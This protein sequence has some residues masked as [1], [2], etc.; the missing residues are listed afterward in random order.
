MVRRNER[1]STLRQRGAAAGSRYSDRATR[2]RSM[3]P[4]GRSVSLGPDRTPRPTDLSSGDANDCREYMIWPLP[5]AND[6]TAPSRQPGCHGHRGGGDD[7]HPGRRGAS[8]EGVRGAGGGLEG[9]AAVD[10]G[11][12]DVGGERADSTALAPPLREA[13]G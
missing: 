2:L 13:R 12:R 6:L 7:L 4:P 8:H 1:G 3:W 10:P 5:R 9:T 11:R